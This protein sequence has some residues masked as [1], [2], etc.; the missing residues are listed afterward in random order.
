MNIAL[1]TDTHFGAR[2]DSKAFDDYFRKFYEDVFFP[3]LKERGIKVVFHL[4]DC[5][6]R[7]KYVNF[8]SLRS[9][10]EYF[11]D[12][13][14]NEGIDIYMIVGNH[15]TYYKNTNDV[16]SPE[17]LLKDYDNIHCFSEPTELTGSFDADILMLPW[18]CTDNYEQ[19][20]K[21]IKNSKSKIC[22]AHLE[23][24]GFQMWKGQEAHDGFD[25]ALFKNFDLVCTGHFHHKH[26]R[27]NITYLGNPYQMFWNDYAD[28]RGFHI[29]DTETLDLEFIEN[30]YIMFEK[31]YY[32]DTKEMG[33]PDQ[34]KDRHLKVVVV[35]KNNTN[36][37]EMYMEK[38]FKA[39]PAE[40]KIVEDF[41][42]FEAD[43]VVG[44]IT[45]VSDT[46]TLLSQ[47]VDALD[48]DVDKERLKNVMKT[49]YLEAQ[50]YEA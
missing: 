37:Y 2:G 33:S 28:P 20:M 44:E 47:Y 27:G 3:T 26:S 25:P 8:D 50:D 45:D 10:R 42:E 29:L 19:S 1:V 13:A 23:L 5:F 24:A 4:G 39:N 18:I 15:D 32:D 30:P 6:D 14:Y 12:K 40:V 31:I 17:L 49:I 46:I 21:A 48:T 34:Y 11:F 38:L 16:N 41:S 35:N 9:C 7:R 36:D 22:F 43:N